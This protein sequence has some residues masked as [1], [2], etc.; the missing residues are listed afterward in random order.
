MDVGYR[1][2]EPEGR[3]EES[4]NKQSAHVL[5]L[6]ILSLRLRAPVAALDQGGLEPARAASR[7]KKMAGEQKTHATV[8]DEDL[9]E[10]LVGPAE[11]AERVD[12]R[13]RCT[14]RVRP[15]RPVGGSVS[16]RRR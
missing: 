14:G 16:V 6:R 8:G 1:Q 12:T 9:S 13:G 3:L 15:R 2:K 10:G 4:Y 5:F 7:I 11:T